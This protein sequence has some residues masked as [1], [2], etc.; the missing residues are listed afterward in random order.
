MPA[1]PPP[2]AEHPF[3][4]GDRISKGGRTGVVFEAEI[5][6]GQYYA[7]LA[8]D[9]FTVVMIGACSLRGC[10]TCASMLT[11]ILAC[12]GPEAMEE[13]GLSMDEEV[14]VAGVLRT[15][16]DVT[17]FLCACSLQQTFAHADMHPRACACEC[18]RAH[19][20]LTHTRR[21]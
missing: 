18:A 5:T 6:A 4:V 19:M 7:A 13:V 20:K 1:S 10:R 8:F 16:G 14:G 21:R 2:E 15:G 3:S 12:A 11:I 9:D 17:A